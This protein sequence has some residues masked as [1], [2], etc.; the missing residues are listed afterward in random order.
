MDKVQSEGGKPTAVEETSTVAFSNAVRLTGREWLVV[1]LFAVLLAGLGPTLWKRVEPV[2]LEPD[3][4]MPYDLGED[5][6]LYQRY[7]ELAAGSYDTIVLGD[8]VV[9]GEYV[10]RHE[11]L[12]HYLNEQAGAE[13]CVNLG[14]DGAHPLALEGLVE[15]YAGSVGGKNVVLHCNPMWLREPKTDLQDPD[16]PVNHHRLV[17]QF[18]PRIPAYKEEISPRIGILVE[19][20][21]PLSR[22]TSHLQQVYYDRLDVPSW[23]LDHPYEDPAAPLRRGLPPPDEG[24][25]HDPLTPWYKSGITLQDFPWIDLDT[26]LQW[27]A[28]QRVVR[29]LLKRENRVFVLVGPFNEHM[30]KP[31]S[32]RRYRAMKAKIA[33]W[34]D[35]EQVPHAVPEALPSEEYGDASHPLR[36]GYARL[37]R[38]LHDE[39]FR[40]R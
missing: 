6:W 26:S 22:W 12:S 13:R 5:Y 33:V 37:A 4:R 30:L 11:T 23:S 24:R 10:S 19:Q 21:L 32:L 39:V 15:H 20:R 17:P 40:Q 18:V 7:A 28:F 31:E 9:W 34:L 16:A 3:H 25:R 36:M 1:G 8:S 27:P 2:A 29:T 38:Q 14:L 35:A